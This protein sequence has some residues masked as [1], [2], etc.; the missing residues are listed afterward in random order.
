MLLHALAL[1]V[2]YQP[3]VFAQS[4]LAIV[5]HAQRTRYPRYIQV[6][7]PQRGMRR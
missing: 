1:N 4:N 5:V 3:V 7:V 6:P 2:L